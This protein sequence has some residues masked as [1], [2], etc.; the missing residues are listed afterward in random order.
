MPKK[1]R[2]QHF[3]PKFY[4]KSFTNENDNK[5]FAYDFAKSCFLPKPVY[6]ESQCFK[7]YF[8]GEDGVWEERLSKMESKWAVAFHKAV[9]GEPLSGDDISSLKELVLFQRQRTSAENNRSKEER[10]S[11]LIEYAKSIY[12]RKGWSFDE[13][14]AR[15]CRERAREDTTPAEHVE[16]ALRMKKYIDDLDVMVIRYT[17]EEKLITTDSPVVVLNPFL[18]IQGYGYA[19]IGVVFLMPI[20]PNSLLVVYD[21][22]LYAKNLG[23]TYVDAY[24]SQEVLSVNQY[25]LIHAERMAFSLNKEFLYSND[26]ISER[27]E[28]E[29]E[30]NKTHYL[31][32]EGH[33]IIMCHPN[34]TN[35][36]LEL[37]FVSLPREYRRIPYQCREAI[38][39]YY[40]S[41]WE[42]KLA[43]KYQ[44]FNTVRRQGSIKTL[45]QTDLKIGCRRMENIAK[46]YWKAHEERHGSKC[47]TDNNHREYPVE[48]P[49]PG[50]IVEVVD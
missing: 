18:G 28:K 6:Y 21:G 36:H 29:R 41:E 24:S 49:R 27:R 23:K 32:P 9:R 13:E 3:V 12:L 45:S 11:I 48:E 4:L 40:D 44:V 20:S 25:E 38:V 26:D 15:F 50:S 43:M 16:V 46:I 35:Y 42:R 10:E 37:P 19:S 14:A 33:R 1:K 31:G 30:T 22:T 39:R 47:W 2:K 17:T 7:E 5:F 34:G 8:Y